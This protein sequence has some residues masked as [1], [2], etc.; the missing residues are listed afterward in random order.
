MSHTRPFRL[1]LALPGLPLPNRSP[2]VGQLS[3]AAYA[4]Q[5]GMQVRC[6][7]ASALE[8]AQLHGLD[9]ELRQ[10]KPDAIGISIFTQNALEAYALAQRWRRLS[11]RLLAG[12]PHAT[13]CPEEALAH[14]FDTVVCGEGEAA[15]RVLSQGRLSAGIHRGSAPIE[16]STLPFPH[17]AVSCFDHPWGGAHVAR[18]SNDVVSS[19]GCPGR[20]QF[21]AN[22]GTGRIHRYRPS[23]HI[24]QEL[25]ALAAQ[26]QSRFFSFLDDAFSAR[27]VRALELCEQLAGHNF[28]F[29]ANVPP[30]SLRCSDFALLAR[31][32]RAVAIGV[33]SGDQE[34][35]RRFGRP[36]GLQR[37]VQV[38]HAAYDAGLQ[39]T[40]NW[41][42]G[43][44][45]ETERA[46]EAT[47]TCMSQLA[48]VS[49]FMNPGGVLVPY[50]GTPVYES[51]HQRFG[52]S[53]WWLDPSRRPAPQLEMSHDPAL[54]LDFFRYSSSQR[55][56]IQRI[57][58]FKAAHNEARIATLRASR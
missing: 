37:I 46:L 11:P 29:S 43:F 55:A 32:C 58:A 21:C 44:P 20:C 57:V 30:W 9:D 31:A 54:E 3:L 24:L 56:L 47:L 22:H 27:R 1:L 18:L 52:F 51:H 10:W 6:V 45:N 26:T 49:T 25:L 23:E 53:R 28:S 40:T 14:G 12:G 50:P 34:I 48:A 8:E 35:L 33:E 13:A 41:M 4:L 42:V 39:V 15:L 17:T 38:V 36:L 5:L 19:R 7:D 16:L 2:Y